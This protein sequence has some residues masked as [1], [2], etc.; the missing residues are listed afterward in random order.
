VRHRCILFQIKAR[1][2]K[3]AGERRP[4]PYSSGADNQSVWL[5]TDGR[6]TLGHTRLSIIDLHTG[7]QPIASGDGRI[8]IVVNGEFYDFERQRCE[9]QQRGH[10]F[11][12]RSDSE[13]A[14]HLYE[15]LGTNCVQHLR[16]EFALVLWDETNQLLLAGRD[17]FG[18]K[19]LYYAVHDG[20]L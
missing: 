6:V 15:D 5:S 20:V 19:P 8:H 1:A 13:I 12:T 11:R 2:G 16:G 9:L 7:D 14:L 3:C 10:H 17:R 4:E 18:I